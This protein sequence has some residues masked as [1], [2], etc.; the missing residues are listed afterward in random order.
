MNLSDTFKK[1]LFGDASTGPH[2]S[3]REF[4]RDDLIGT[5][6]PVI[7][8]VL[9][10]GWQLDADDPRLEPFDFHIHK[11]LTKASQIR[12]MVSRGLSLSRERRFTGPS[13]C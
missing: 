8:K 4:S 2:P 12:G 5:A 7:A 1:R 11:P 13:T 6:D 10:S 9:I 3:T